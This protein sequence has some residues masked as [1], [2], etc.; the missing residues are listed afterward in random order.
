VQEDER[1]LRRLRPPLGGAR[2]GL[3]R[4]RHRL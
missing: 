3:R 2:L 4:H 1:R